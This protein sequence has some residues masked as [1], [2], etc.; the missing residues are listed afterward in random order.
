[1]RSW[2]ALTL[3]LAAP[4]L[5]N[6]GARDRDGNLRYRAYFTADFVWHTALTAELTR[7]TL[8]PPGNPYLAPERIHYYWAY[9]L[10][11]AAIARSGPRLYATSSAASR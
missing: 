2:S 9:F 6:V 4:P 10:V 8:P 7:F 5:A 1:M 11:P 3:A